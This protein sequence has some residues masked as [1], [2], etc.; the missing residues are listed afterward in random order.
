MVKHRSL[1]GDKFKENFIQSSGYIY[2]DTDDIEDLDAYKDY[3]I[4]KYGH[5]V[6]MVC[7]SSSCGGLSILFK[8]TNVIYSQEEFLYVWDNIRTTILKDEMIDIKCK[9]FGRVNFISFDPEVYVNYD[10]EITI[11]FSNFISE[12]DET[13]GIKSVKH[14]ISR[15][16][17]NN[18]MSY[19]FLEKGDKKFSIISIYEVLK[20]INTKTKVQ[21]ENIIVDFKPIEYAE[22]YIPKHIKDGTKHTIYTKIIHQLVY[23]NPDIEQEY[24]FSYLWYINNNHARPKMEIRELTRLFKM[25]YDNIKSTGEIHPKVNIKMV[26]FNSKSELTS[27]EKNA[28]ANILLGYFRRYKSI[29][30]V[31]AAKEELSKKG[32][33]Y[34]QKQVAQ[35]SGLSLRTVKTYFKAEAIDMD[36]VIQQMNDPETKILR[37]IPTG[38]GL[39]GRKPKY[40][41]IMPPNAYIHPDC[42]QWVFKMAEQYL[43]Q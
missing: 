19:T 5:L 22:V 21:V 29:N 38:M 32:L 17:D 9:D 34:T 24:I 27:K 10:N 2:I 20:K 15:K 4:K 42:P 28:V 25:V 39:N 12:N 37:E 13:N 6:S 30:K 11:D 43:H 40:D 36:L 8:I 35:A 14:P 3:F 33:K 23:L 1:K 7:K 16:G 31:L 18:R 26:H 41:R